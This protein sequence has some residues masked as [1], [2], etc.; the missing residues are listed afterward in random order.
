MT[1]YTPLWEQQGSYAASVDR[2][3]LSALWPGAAVTG[4]AVTVSSGMTVNVA[5]GSVA[6][7]TSNNTGSVLCSSDATEPVTLTAAPG[8]GTNRYDVIICQARGNDLDGGANNDF[9]FTMV[10]GT[11]AASPTVP[12]TPNNAVALANIYVPGAS[13]SVTAGN[14]TDVRNAPTSA[15]DPTY[16]TNS[17]LWR[18]ANV[19][20]ASIAQTH[21]S[22]GASPSLIIPANRRI[23][24]RAHFYWTGSGTFPQAIAKVDGTEI[25]AATGTIMIPWGSAVSATVFEGSYSHTPAAGAHTYDINVFCGNGTVAIDGSQAG[26]YE[27]RDIGQA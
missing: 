23:E 11:A 10:T 27:V 3:L 18:R 21:I 8:A 7:P 16:K 19:T 2:R 25:A 4:C 13:A 26:W 1:R 12:A 15:F 5:A 17:V 6:V 9:L 22:L 24:L 20:Q 14:I